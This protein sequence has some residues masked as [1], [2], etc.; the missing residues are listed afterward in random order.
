MTK[1]GSEWMEDWQAAELVHELRRITDPSVLKTDQESE[2][3]RKRAEEIV[4]I[5]Q[6]WDAEEIFERFGKYASVL[7]VK[8]MLIS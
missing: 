6:A 7:S 5:F 3:D 2:E 1:V 8:S 4:R